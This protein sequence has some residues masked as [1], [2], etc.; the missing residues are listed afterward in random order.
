MLEMVSSLDFSEMNAWEQACATY[1]LARPIRLM[2]DAAKSLNDAYTE[3]EPL[4]PLLVKHRLLAIT[5]APLPERLSVLRKLAA[6][7]AV[8]PC[9]MQ[10]V[11]RFEKARFSTLKNEATA[12]IKSANV[13]WVD[14]L[15]EEVTGEPWQSPVPEALKIALFRASASLHHDDALIRLREMV[16]RIREAHA[17][18]NLD[19]CREVFSEWAL[20]V[21]ESNVVVPEDLL[22]EIL[23]LSRLL[24]QHQEGQEREREFAA[25]CVELKAAFDLGAPAE[26]LRQRY[27]RI[28]SFELEVPEELDAEYR[29]KLEAL[30]REQKLEKRR[31]LMVAL[32]LGIAVAAAMGAM[33]IVMMMSGKH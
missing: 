19:E 26:E 21:Q 2:L 27:R 11:E 7:D 24:D 29:K 25:A 3:Q 18:M 32:V 6:E 12:A 31:Q 20:I 10:D 23:P 15:L 16:P 4:Q 28:L 14:R 30:A 9:W 8:S 5:N 17:A 1:G 33:A 13:A 22:G